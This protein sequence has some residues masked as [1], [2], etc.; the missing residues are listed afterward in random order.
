MLRKT[1]GSCT[2]DSNGTVPAGIE[3]D[4]IGGRIHRARVLVVVAVVP[5]LPVEVEAETHHLRRGLHFLRSGAL[6]TSKAPVHSCSLG[7]NQ[8]MLLLS[9]ASLAKQPLRRQ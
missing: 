3:G 5:Q 1:G 9:R 4:E 2:I 7:A 8:T 6:S